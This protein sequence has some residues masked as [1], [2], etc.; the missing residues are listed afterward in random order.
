MSLPRP[1]ITILAHFEPLFTAPTWKKVVILFVGTVLARGRRTVTTA[2]RQVGRQMDRHFSGF[3]QV[4]N[5]ARWSPLAVSRRLLQVL[6]QTFVHAGGMVEIV[7]DETLERRWGRKI[8]KRGHW[9]DSLLSSKERS[10]STSGLRWVTM[11]LVVT[12]PWTKRRWALPFLS[13]LTT[14][15]KVS[16]GLKRRHKTLARLA[17]QMVMVVR[18]WLPDVAIKVIGDGAY[19]VIELGLTCLKLQVSL[20]APLRLDARLFA[21]P[22]APRPHQMG[23]PPVVGKR[24][25]K[26]TTVLHDPNTEWET[27]TVNWYG[28]IQRTLEVTT[29][30]ALWYSTGTDPLPIRWVLTRDPEGKR[31]PKAYFSTDQAQSAKEIVEDFVKRWSL[32]VT[33]EESRAHLGVETQRQ[34]SDLAIER[35]T[36]CLLGLYSL[37][38]LLAHALHPDGNVPV[39]QAAWYPK[40]HATFGDILATVRRHLWGGLTSQTVASHP[41]LCLVP[42]ADLARLLQA[43]CY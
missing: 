3:H 18:R 23:R 41:D 4:L 37:V 2:L 24:L 5:R 32:E 12:L 8:S 19:S 40:T 14:T 13:V 31:E 30:T 22:P 43:A 27:L 11:A 7:M 36:P 29:G 28:G 35:S 6:V 21:P 42:R 1:I 34:W 38:V 20:I 9:R 25:P 16:E 10:V 33:Y 39:Q 15:P 17:Q 26:L